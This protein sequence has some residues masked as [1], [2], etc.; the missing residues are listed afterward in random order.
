MDI[1]TIEDGKYVIELYAVLD[2][3]VMLF[4]TQMDD[5]GMFNMY[6]QFVVSK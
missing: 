4:S 3:E 5:D 6:L 1:L 2:E